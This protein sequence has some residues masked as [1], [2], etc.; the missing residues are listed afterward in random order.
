[1]RYAPC[2]KCGHH[3]EID[4]VLLF[5]SVFDW[6][7]CESCDDVYVKSQYGEWIESNPYQE[8]IQTL[9]PW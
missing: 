3:N 9:K 7:V 1:M 5:G 8:Y 6:Y 2:L 4:Q